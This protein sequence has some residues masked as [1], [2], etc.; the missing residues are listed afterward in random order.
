MLALQGAALGSGF[1]LLCGVYAGVIH[2]KSLPM[3][4]HSAPRNKPMDTA[5]GGAGFGKW[6][7]TALDCT[8]PKITSYIAEWKEATACVTK[9]E[10]GAWHNGWCKHPLHRR[11]HKA[12][13]PGSIKTRKFHR[14]MDYAH[15]KLHHRASHLTAKHVIHG[16]WVNGQLWPTKRRSACVSKTFLFEP[17]RFFL[18]VQR[19]DA[20]PSIESIDIPFASA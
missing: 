13:E 11:N 14:Y 7:L 15:T 12:A 18:F 16:V 20:L 10:R 19:E 3:L 2:L 5:Q 1:V 9:F 6:R 4:R 17:S 8:D